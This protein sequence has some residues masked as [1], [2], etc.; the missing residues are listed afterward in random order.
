[1]LQATTTKLESQHPKAQRYVV[2]MGALVTG[3]GSHGTPCWITQLSREDIRL[4]VAQPAVLSVKRLSPGRTV[5][6]HLSHRTGETWRII[7]LKAAVIGAEGNTFSARI[8]APTSHVIEGLLRALLVQGKA[9]ELSGPAAEKTSPPSSPALRA[10]LAPARQIQRTTCDRSAIAQICC[11]VVQDFGAKW[12]SNFLD[13]ID[14]LLLAHI[15]KEDNRQIIN[16]A[17]RDSG[18]ALCAFYDAL[19]AALEKVGL[20]P[21]NPMAE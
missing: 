16:D 1:M 21:A 7:P 13:R 18:S 20:E 11:E 12:V 14:E 19:S 17:L 5:M 8:T 10:E 2:W 3:F 9:K 6:V 15:S 4:T